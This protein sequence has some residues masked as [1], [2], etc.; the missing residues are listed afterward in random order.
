[1]KIGKKYVEI[2]A[3][4]G[5]VWAVLRQLGLA[6]AQIVRP[7]PKNKLFDLAFMGGYA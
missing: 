1:M 7:I 5:L 4:T 2:P 3:D 6:K